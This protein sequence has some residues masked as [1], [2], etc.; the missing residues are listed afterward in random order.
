[1][2]FDPKRADVF[3]LLEKLKEANGTYPQD[4]LALRRQGY[5]KQVAAIG[6]GGGLALALKQTAKGAKNAV[7]LPS[8]ASTMLEGILVVAIVAEAGAVTYFYR[9]K[10]AEL[11]QKLTTSPKVEVVTSPP[12]YSS[13]IPG[14]DLTPS[15]VV[16]GTLTET[17]TTIVTPSMLAV[18][19][20]EKQATGSTSNNDSSQAVSTATPN[21]GTN[22]GNHYGNTPMPER[23]KD[24]GSNNNSG[25]QTNQTNPK[26]KP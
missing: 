7:G 18:Q 16:T 21:D 20:T 6:G 10:L 26:K 22:N 23:T 11:Y 25:D 3:Q 12:V 14:V 13:P 17:A 5:L 9:D 2:E 19:P 24:S 15:P 1:M 4:L 8:T